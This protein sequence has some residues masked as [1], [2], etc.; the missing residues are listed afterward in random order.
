[1]EVFRHDWDGVMNLRSL[2]K[3]FSWR[4]GCNV[5]KFSDVFRFAEMRV[6]CYAGTKNCRSEWKYRAIGAIGCR[7]A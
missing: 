2:T 4:I 1:M 3:L 7:D 6:A 5:N